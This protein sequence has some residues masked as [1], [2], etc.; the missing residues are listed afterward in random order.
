MNTFNLRISKLLLV[1]FAFTT[2]ACEDNESGVELI[3]L[4][5]RFTTELNLRTVSFNNISNDATSYLWDFGDGTSS[6]LL[7]PIKTY[8]NGTYTVSLTAFNDNGDADVFEKTLIIDVAICDDEMAEN[9]DPANG[10]INWTFLST[11][12]TATFDAFGNIGGS[13]VAN[14]YFENDTNTSCNV[15]KYEKISGCETWSGVGVELNTAL[16]FS[17]SNADKVFKMKVFAENQ[18]TEVTLRLERLPFPNTEPSHDR[19]ATIT[20]LGQWQEL[21]FDFSDVNTGTYK[22]MIIYFERN[23]PCDGD[24][25]YFDDIL[26]Q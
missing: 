18:L 25:Y 12:S 1:V 15:Y 23:A 4:E 21:T 26:Q 24:V 16:D 10:N 17:V 14:P 2:L 8:Q 3:G 11:D 20:Q 9:I 13:I 19:V 5:A 7:N 6:I 22:S